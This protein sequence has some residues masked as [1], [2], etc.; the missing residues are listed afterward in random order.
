MSEDEIRRIQEEKDE[1]IKFF[2]WSIADMKAHKMLG[3]TEGCS[4]SDMLF[5]NHD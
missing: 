1:V 5:K 3:S 2:S 4:P